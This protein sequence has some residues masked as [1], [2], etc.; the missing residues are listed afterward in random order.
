MEF[1]VGLSLGDCLI[2]T[3]RGPLLKQLTTH[4]SYQ[5]KQTIREQLRT[6]VFVSEL[7]CCSKGNKQCSHRRP[8]PECTCSGT[9]ACD[10]CCAGILLQVGTSEMIWKLIC[11]LLYCHQELHNCPSGNLNVNLLICTLWLTSNSI[12]IMMK[13]QCRNFKLDP[14]CKFSL[15]LTVTC[16]MK[17]HRKVCTTSSNA[18]SY[19]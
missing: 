15:G 12:S 16:C 10:H 3:W 18:L 6:G 11:F 17:F 2:S 1:Y 4:Q 7:H 19:E 14:H 9:A 8:N 5:M 13:P